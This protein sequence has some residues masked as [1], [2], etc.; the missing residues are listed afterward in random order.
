[1]EMDLTHLLKEKGFQ[2]GRKWDPT[3]CCTQETRLKQGAYERLTVREWA[4][5]Q[6]GTE[7]RNKTRMAIGIRQSKCDRE[8]HF[9]C[10]KPQFTI[11]I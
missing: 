2:L 9:S 11:Q 4:K 6:Q 10:Q 5:V 7:T 1:M 8:R 3:G